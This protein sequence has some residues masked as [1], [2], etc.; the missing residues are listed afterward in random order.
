MQSV[1]IALL[2]LGKRKDRKDGGKSDI[3]ALFSIKPLLD[4]DM[5]KLKSHLGARPKYMPVDANDQI[6]EN[7]QSSPRDGL[8]DDDAT[9]EARLNA[10][11]NWANT[12]N[13][14]TRIHYLASFQGLVIVVLVLFIFY[15]HHHRTARTVLLGT[16]PS[17]FVP[18]G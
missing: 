11:D 15:S 9:R 4:L 8:Y 7:S 17:G 3:Q 16:D 14:L 5:E 12:S 13:R 6:E 1:N 18:Q 10:A 2:L